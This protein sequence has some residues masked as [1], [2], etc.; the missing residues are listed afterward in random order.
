MIVV[1]GDEHGGGNGKSSIAR[2]SHWPAPAAFATAEVPALGSTDGRIGEGQ[3]RDD[4][5]ATVQRPDDDGRRRRAKRVRQP[6]TSASAKQ[7]RP[8]FCQCTASLR[9]WEQHGQFA[10]MPHER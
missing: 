8:T 9:K 10:V 4:A 2:N 3:R 6:A 7:D 1:A 5:F